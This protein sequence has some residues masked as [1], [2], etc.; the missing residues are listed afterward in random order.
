PLSFNEPLSILSNQ[1]SAGIGFGP[2]LCNQPDVKF[3][4]QLV[5]CLPV[6]TDV[7]NLLHAKRGKAERI[8][9]SRFERSQ[10]KNG[11]D[12]IVLDLSDYVVFFDGGKSGSP[13]IGGHHVQAIGPIAVHAVSREVQVALQKEPHKRRFLEVTGSGVGALRD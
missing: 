4:D 3:T 5:A 7:M 10:V 9:F 13:E 2:P 11:G 12:L 8:V 1:Q 6:V